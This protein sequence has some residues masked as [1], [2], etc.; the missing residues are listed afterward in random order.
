MF[1]NPTLYVFGRF[2]TFLGNPTTN[3]VLKNQIRNVRCFSV[4]NGGFSDH[5]SHIRSNLS[6]LQHDLTFLAS[7]NV[8]SQC[9]LLEIKLKDPSNS[10]L[11]SKLSYLTNKGGELEKLVYKI[12]DNR[13]RY[14]LVK[15]RRIT[16][17]SNYK[18]G[19]VGVSMICVFGSLALSL[20]PIFLAVTFP[21]F[22]SVFRAVPWDFTSTGWFSSSRCY[23]KVR[24]ATHTTYTHTY[25]LA[26][27][28]ISH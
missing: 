20:N 5:I 21:D 24:C 12:L 26:L 25:A 9:H 14:N 15:N 23:A 28:L 17:D 8:K 2:H 13:L 16:K 6:A 10:A 4:S 7:S 27:R 3:S 19:I 1:L 11:S 18:Y 22:I